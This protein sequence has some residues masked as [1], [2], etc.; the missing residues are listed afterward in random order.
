ML[1]GV[2]LV[3]K[4]QNFVLTVLFI[5]TYG[6]DTTD[7]SREVNSFDINDQEQWKYHN[8]KGIESGEIKFCYQ[9]FYP[10]TIKKNSPK[11]QIILFSYYF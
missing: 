11:V 1:F 5:A 9:D 4:M 7:K 6:A 8:Q 10:Y 3:Q 2:K